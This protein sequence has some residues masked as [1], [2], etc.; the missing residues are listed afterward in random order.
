[1]TPTVDDVFDIDALWAASRIFRGQA[2]SP[3]NPGGDVQLMRH[4]AWPDGTYWSADE[5]LVDPAALR[6][7]RRYTEAAVLTTFEPG[8][9][10]VPTMLNSIT[11]LDPKRIPRGVFPQPTQ[12]LVRVDTHTTAQYAQAY[13]GTNMA[14]CRRKVR[15]LS[16]RAR[17]VFQVFGWVDGQWLH[18]GDENGPTKPTSPWSKATTADVDHLNQMLGYQLLSEYQ[19]RAVF[20]EPG[21][22]PFCTPTDAAGARELFRLRDKPDDVK[23]RP[24]LRHWVGEHMRRRP[25][26]PR[27]AE[28]DVFVIN[29]LRG[30]TR[31]TWSGID[32]ELRPSLCDLELAEKGPGAVTRRA[33]E[34]GAAA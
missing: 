1:M 25:G 7:W 19:W 2:R 6:P 4:V 16:A 11:A 20:T 29:H 33:A 32:V 26:A 23:R 3:I 15:R 21:L 5:F 22:A 10:A 31:F 8:R 27:D 24:A 12:W 30:R 17:H 9:Q 28:A 34:N 13:D 14:D 18:L